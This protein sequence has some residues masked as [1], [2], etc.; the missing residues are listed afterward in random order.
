MNKQ[1]VLRKA[2]NINASA[3]K[4]WEALVTPEWIKQ[5]LFGTN[6]ISDWKV[7]SPIVFTGTW[8]G[9]EYKDKGT[10]LKFEKEK[11]LQYDYW[12]GFSGLPDLP[13]NYSIITFELS[14]HAG[15][16]TLSL[17]QNNF[18]DEKSLEHSGKNWEGVLQTMKGLLEKKKR[19]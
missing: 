3:S 18:V 2:V 9:K 1:L 6:T 15:Q 4:V 7:G 8:E 16:T 14:S 17:T 12:S 11:M 5:Y 10:I 13:E 19:T